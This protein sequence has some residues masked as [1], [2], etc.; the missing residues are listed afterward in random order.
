[1]VLSKVDF[2][3]NFQKGVLGGFHFLK[4]TKFPVS[5]GEIQKMKA[6]A[7]D[8]ICSLVSH[9]RVKSQGESTNLDPQSQ[10]VY[11]DGK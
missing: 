1:M 7:F 11:S 5:L 2:L 9:G 6:F 4:A 8:E 3:N 10:G